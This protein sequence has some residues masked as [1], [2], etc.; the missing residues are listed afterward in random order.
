[1]TDEFERAAAL[2]EED[3]RIAAINHA[4]RAK[5]EAREDCADCGDDLAP[6][7]V[8]FGT[9]VSCQTDRETRDRQRKGPIR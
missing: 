9:C 6:H 2:E 7:R 3:R 1:M 5:P 8:E 4:H